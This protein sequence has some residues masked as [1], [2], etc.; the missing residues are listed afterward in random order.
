MNYEDF[1][2]VDRGL[3]AEHISLGK[4]QSP[5]KKTNPGAR[6]DAPCAPFL[7]YETPFGIIMMGKMD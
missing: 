2:V 7:S 4:R 1:V 3:Q 6:K 5:Q